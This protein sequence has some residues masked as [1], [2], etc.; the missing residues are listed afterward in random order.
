MKKKPSTI[1][2]VGKKAQVIR[3]GIRSGKGSGKKSKDGEQRGTLGQ[4]GVTCWGIK[5]SG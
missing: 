5:E 2:R 1:R 4:K 3:M